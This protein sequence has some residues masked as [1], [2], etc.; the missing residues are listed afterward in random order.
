MS[1]EY[2]LLDVPDVG[3]ELER[4]IGLVQQ[5]RIGD[6]EY[7]WEER[8]G[9]FERS[10]EFHA[11]RNKERMLARY[12]LHCIMD[13]ERPWFVGEGDDTDNLFR[14]PDPRFVVPSTLDDAM[15]LSGMRGWEIAQELVDDN[16]RTKKLLGTLALDDYVNLA[17]ATAL[18]GRIDAEADLS[19]FVVDDSPSTVLRQTVGGTFHGDFFAGWKRFATSGPSIDP[20]GIRRNFAP[21]LEGDLVRAYHSVEDKLA[22]GMLTYLA[23]GD[24]T[25]LERTKRAIVED[26]DAADMGRGG[27][28][29]A[30]FGSNGSDYAHEIFVDNFREYQPGEVIESFLVT[31]GDTETAMQ[32]VAA[33]D[34]VVLQNVS[35]TKQ[36]DGSI[37]TELL[38]AMPISA[39]EIPIFIATMAA[40]SA[41]RT[42]LKEI[43][44]AIVRAKVWR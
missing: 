40:A 12:T 1:R 38:S 27:G 11:L 31:P 17:V 14:L 21:V 35:H 34:G 4:Y 32:L 29:F 25:K 5:T 23:A 3:R 30:D 20:M 41:G 36:D 10:H 18:Y 33:H 26:I 7:R 9:E 2:R 15:I 13:E 24:D 42:S 6:L 8:W 43:R 19:Y 44:T 28:N 39:Q 37:Q 16:R 22:V